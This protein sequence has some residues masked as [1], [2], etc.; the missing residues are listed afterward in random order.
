MEIY[1]K[2]KADHTLCS[3][4]NG[5]SLTTIEKEKFPLSGVK[6]SLRPDATWNSQRQHHHTK[7][8]GEFQWA[9]TDAGAASQSPST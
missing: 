8:A 6:Q 5:S 4:A 2:G 1:L 9:F 7:R 3:W